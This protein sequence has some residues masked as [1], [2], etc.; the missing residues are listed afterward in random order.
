MKSKIMP[1]IFAVLAAS[2]YALNIPLSKYLMNDVSPTMLAGLLYLGAGIGVGIM[3]LFNIKK[4]K[5]EEFLNKKDWPYILGMIALDIIAPIMLMFGLKYTTSGN[6]S[7]LNNFEIVATSLIA[8]LIFKEAISKKLWIGI[9][10]VTLSASL[11]TIDVSS[12]TF[13]W[14][15]LL[16]IGAAICWGFENNCT[17]KISNKSI[18]EIVTI[19]GLSCG[20]GSIIIALIIGERFPNWMY[21]LFALLLG[22]VAYGLSIYFYI[23][24]QNK[25]GAAKTSAFYAIN[26]FIAVVLSLILFKEVPTWNFYIALGIMII[27]SIIIV[28]DT[29]EKVHKHMHIHKLTHTHDGST[30]T[31]IIEHNHKHAH[32]KDEDEHMHHHSEKEL[33]KELKHKPI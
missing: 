27:G 17:R 31:H 5:K 21:L 1:V 7:L 26:A 12:F 8:L 11:L 3:F 18:Y 23:K 30:H 13:S 32:I 16:I 20:I 29:L 15:S 14:G 33:L 22:F 28:I 9:I 4:T 10:L 24:A 19:K 2:F 6:A 25:L